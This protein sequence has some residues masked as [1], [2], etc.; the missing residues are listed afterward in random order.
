[1]KQ[2]S[3][4]ILIFIFIQSCTL[5]SQNTFIELDSKWKKEVMLGLSGKYVDYIKVRPRD[6]IHNY[7]LDMYNKFLDINRY[8]FDVGFMQLKKE[9]E[10]K[11]INY[12]SIIC[13]TKQLSSNFD[14]EYLHSNYY[15]VFKNSKIINVFIFE[16][17]LLELKESNDNLYD[18]EKMFLGDNIK[19][20]EDG[21]SLLV[22]TKIKPDW[23]FDI[24]KIVINSY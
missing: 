23:S 21:M 8:P 24:V 11:I 19:T 6:S 17:E 22:F 18:L 10:S 7:E 3:K 2:Y 1:M 5:T 9:I 20:D 16:P 15:Y 13:I 4:F 12:D 14:P